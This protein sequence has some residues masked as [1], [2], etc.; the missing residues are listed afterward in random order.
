METAGGMFF[1]PFRTHLLH[2]A[3]PNP[4]VCY[5][6][7]NGLW[8]NDVLAWAILFFRFSNLATSI[9]ETVFSRQVEG[10]RTM[11]K[12]R[13]NNELTMCYKNVDTIKREIFLQNF[14]Q[15]ESCI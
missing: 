10:E 1:S 9:G 7:N 12:T 4:V 2:L 3:A 14:A 15:V 11:P 6:I 13:A 8:G 5:L